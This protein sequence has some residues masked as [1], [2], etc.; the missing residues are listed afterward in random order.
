MNLNQGYE[1]TESKLP[2]REIALDTS[3]TPN[4][5][6]VVR[7]NGNQSNRN[8]RRSQTAQGHEPQ[9]SR[10]VGDQGAHAPT[11]V[12]RTPYNYR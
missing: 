6:E 2:P 12:N 7:N 9:R 8:N 3:H 11:P 5:C 1:M 10:Q 4:Q